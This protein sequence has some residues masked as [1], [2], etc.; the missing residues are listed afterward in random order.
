MKWMPLALAMMLLYPMAPSAEGYS[1]SSDYAM[2]IT[3]AGKI[4]QYYR[5]PGTYTVKSQVISK[6]NPNYGNYTYKVWYP[7]VLEERDRTW[8]M[9]FLLNGT[10]GSCYNDEPLYEHLASWGFLV[11]GNTD[12]QT[13]LGYS[14][15]YDWEIMKQLSETAESVFY[16][17]VDENHMAIVGYSQGGAGAYHAL[18]RAGGDRYKTIVTVS[19]VTKSISRKLHLKS[20]LYD[21]SQVKIPAFQVAGT[22]PLDRKLISPLAEMRE[23]FSQMKEAPYGVMGRRKRAD[24]LDIQEQAD[25]YITAWLRWQ[26]KGD[27]YAKRVFT[28]E[29]PEILHN[30]KWDNVA[31]VKKSEKK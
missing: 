26:L 29:Q 18:E 21:T 3:D 12:S 8:P 14:A 15:S 30:P 23:N 17:K 13:G 19:A 24:H 2:E 27:P 5:L 11:V 20:W 6:K 9:V 25:A 1:I 31:I 16:G 4:E 22:G 7:A 28:G 10:G